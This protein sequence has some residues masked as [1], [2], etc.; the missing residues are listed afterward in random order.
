MEKNIIS[1]SKALQGGV[2]YIE[3]LE[4]LTII[5]NRFLSNP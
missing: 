3:N 1:F 4:N 2:I 5:N